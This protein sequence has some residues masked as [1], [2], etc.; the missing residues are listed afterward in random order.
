MEFRIKIISLRTA[1]S[2]QR[3]HIKVVNPDTFAGYSKGI[4][5]T[6]TLAYYRFA[7]HSS[8]PPTPRARTDTRLCLYSFLRNN[9]I[10]WLP[11]DLLTGMGKLIKL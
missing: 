11:E 6:S 1:P 4:M 7:D 8:P 9:D 10:T 3:Q 5:P 2:I